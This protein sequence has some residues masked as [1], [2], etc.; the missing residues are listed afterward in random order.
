M[1][2]EKVWTLKKAKKY[3]WNQFS[4]YIRTRDCLKTTGNPG[5]G[6]CITCGRKYDFRGLQA[7]HFVQG[8][9]NNNLFSEKGV[10]AQCFYCN[11]QLRGNVLE[12]RRKIIALYGDGADLKLEAEDKI[13]KKYTLKD[14]L[15]LAD[16][17]IA[18]TKALLE[19]SNA[20]VDRLIM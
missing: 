8:R 14:Y 3:A 10:H 12:Y 1:A 19:P 6:V 17:F 4:I 20:G 15:E 7:G 2:K 11:M 18:Q 13:L 9:H 16:K 5:E